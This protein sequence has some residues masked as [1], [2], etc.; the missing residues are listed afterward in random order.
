MSGANILAEWLKESFVHSTKKYNE[1]ISFDFGITQTAED[2]SA[3]YENIH[4]ALKSS[5]YSNKIEIEV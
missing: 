2:L 3:V 1:Q 5:E 4:D